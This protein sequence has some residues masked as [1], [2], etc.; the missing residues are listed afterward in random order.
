[1]ATTNLLDVGALTDAESMFDHP[2]TQPATAAD[3][4]RLFDG[5][6]ALS[7]LVRFDRSKVTV[8]AVQ[9][10]EQIEAAY[11]E[12]AEREAYRADLITRYIAACSAGADEWDQYRLLAEAARYDKAH[13]GDSVPLADELH[14]TQ[15]LAE[16]A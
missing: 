6:A 12:A 13:P 3:Y 8:G 2:L 7:E 10:A 14:G 4:A 15:L 1:M 9:R 11:A 16:A 5:D